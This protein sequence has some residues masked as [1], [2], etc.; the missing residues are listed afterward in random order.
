MLP[1]GAAAVALVTAAALG[2]LAAPPAPDAGAAA[3]AAGRAPSSPRPA[4]G[5]AVAARGLSRPPTPEE[6]LRAT[7][8]RCLTPA[9]LRAAYGLPPLG[10]PGPTGAGVTVGIVDSFGS[11]TLARDLA[12]YDQQFGLP[13]LDL[14]VVSPAGPPPPFRAADHDMA[15]WAGETTLD[16]EVVHAIAPG[17]RILLATTPVAETEGLQ[18]FPEIVTSENAILDRIDVLTQ[19]FAATEP[20]FDSPDQIRALSA[21]IYPRAR[22]AGVTV[23]ASSGDNGPVD[24]MLDQHTLF[25]RPVTDWPASDPLVTAVGG[26]VVRVAADGSRIVPDSAWGGV[27]GGGAGGGGRSEVFGRPAFQDGVAAVVGEHRGVPDLALD[28]SGVTGL[29][30]YGSYDATGWSVGG[31]T[32]QAAPILA[33]IV[34][35]ADGQAGAR[36]GFLNDALYQ[37]AAAGRAGGIVDI[38]DGSNQLVDATGRPNPVPGYPARPGYDLATGLGTV[39]AARLIPALINA[40]RGQTSPLA[41]DRP[42]GRTGSAGTGSPRGATG[43]AAARPGP[44]PVTARHALRGRAGW[45]ALIGGMALLVA[46]GA[47]WRLSRSRRPLRPGG[48]GGAMR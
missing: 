36:L 11:P 39:D 20:T 47:A 8:A 43:P 34:A 44:R 28:A 14:Q 3:R 26:S 2:A 19:S 17:A 40:R 45:A 5:G 4:R 10:G 23:L 38:T 37:L 32:S 25:T 1:A 24:E 41:R 22:Q 48:R 27:P 13:P 29:I 21:R 16:V 30:T 33:G 42:A 18:G 7:G 12:A 9:M 15:G 31:G 35:L 46:A 6:C